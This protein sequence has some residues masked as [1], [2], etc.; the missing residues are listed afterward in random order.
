[1]DVDKIDTDKFTTV[2][3]AFGYI[4][5]DFTV[6]AE[7][8]ENQF[9]KFKKMTGVKKV[10]SFGGWAFSNEAPTSSRMRNAVKPANAA[11]FAT[12][13]Y[14]FVMDNNLDGV[15]F[16][17]EY[18]GATDIDGSDPGTPE[19]GDNYLNFLTLVKR[20]F[21]SSKTVAI[22][23]PS[24]YWY[25]RNFPIKK[26]SKVVDYIVYMTYDL[27]GQW[28]VGNEWSMEGCEGGNC[29]R[30]HVNST[31][32]YN[33]I[34]LITKA[35]VPQYKVVMGVTSYGRSFKMAKVGCADPD[36]TFQGSRDNSSA[37]PGECTGQSGYIANAEIAEIKD[38]ADADV[39]GSYYE[40]HDD[41][42]DSDIIVYNSDE[43]VAYMTDETKESRTVRYDKWFMG[44]TS[45]WAIDLDKDYGSSSNGSD[46]D[47]DWDVMDLT[48]D[49]KIDKKYAD[50]DELDADAS[51]LPYQCVA[52][53]AIELLK[54]MLD[55]SLDGYDGAADGY[56]GLFD[57][58]A[59]YMKK[60]LNGRLKELMRE[61]A[62]NVEVGPAVK[63]FKCYAAEGLLVNRKDAKEVDCAD[64]PREYLMDYT[65]Y[66]ELDD[67]DGFN[68]TLQEEGIS[69]EWVTFDKTSTEKVGC[70]DSQGNCIQVTYVY[71]GFPEKADDIEI[72]DPKE[73]VAEAR[74]NMG[75][76]KMNYD[77]MTMEVGFES[78]DGKLGDIL[79][80]LSTPI[81]MLE[82]AV[83]QMKEIKKIGNEWKGKSPVL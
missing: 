5:E 62:R 69:A 27:H 16:D 48:Y 37:A 58:Y 65:Y 31:L 21:K 12:N 83:S 25:L 60:T 10:I 79:D 18:P 1:M 38:M 78:W 20:R 42:S 11:A 9:K 45:D 4:N 36:C 44:G 3:F 8:V 82:D 15:D 43:W 29:L 59:D 81:F 54:G 73:I 74:K 46:D 53:H 55:D 14:N 71:V 76:L 67:E 64:L 17:W 77:E 56:D 63:Y 39:M 52:M 28:D 19:D 80:V 68:S 34:A 70:G 57:E 51:S 26:M 6:S 30:S 47:F 75:S 24:S 33:S 13:V 61:P 32:T 49:C 23:A 35:G 72:P 7:G 40:Y 50:L 2:H 66:Y 41:D 22:A